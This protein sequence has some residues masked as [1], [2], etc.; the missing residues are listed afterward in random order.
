MNRLKK[1]VLMNLVTVCGAV[2]VS[3]LLDKS[4]SLAAAL[5]VNRFIRIIAMN[6]VALCIDDCVRSADW[7]LR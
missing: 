2:Y 1:I 4:S 7:P 6:L 3:G 5:G